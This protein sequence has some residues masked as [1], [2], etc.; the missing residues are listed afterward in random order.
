MSNVK[1]MYFLNGEMVIGDLK[2]P[3]DLLEDFG[4]ITVTNPCTISLVQSAENAER[5]GVQLRPWCPFSETNKLKVSR[6]HMVYITEPIVDLLN[7]YQKLFGSGLVI[8][9][10]GEVPP[11]GATI[12]RI[13]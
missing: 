8:A 6:S 13:K 1:V 10:P 12:H 5:V 4:N 9:K 7:Q 11:P 3:E 2:E